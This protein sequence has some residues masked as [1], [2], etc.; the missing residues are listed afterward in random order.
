MLEEKKRPRKTEGKRKKNDKEIKVQDLLSIL[1]GV[2]KLAKNTFFGGN[3]DNSKIKQLI[4]TLQ[5]IKGMS[6]SQFI[7][8]LSNALDKETSDDKQQIYSMEISDYSNLD[9]RNIC[10]NPE[11]VAKITLEE[12]G[13]EKFGLSQS[14]LKSSSKEKVAKLILSS[15]DNMEILDSIANKAKG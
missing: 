12:I 15:L 6:M 11:T 7:D 5:P 1:E 8:F 3:I 10:M 9:I 13:H 2:Q 14:L 4:K